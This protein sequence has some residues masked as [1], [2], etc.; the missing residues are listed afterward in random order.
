[1]EFNG[2]KIYPVGDAKLSIENDVLKVSDISDSGFDGIL[3]STKDNNKY[4]VNFGN[5][6]SISE[7]NGVLKCTT[8]QKNKLN[9]I[10]TSF[11][12]FSWYDPKSKK[13]ILGYNMDYIPNKFTVFG[14]LEGEIVYEFDNSELNPVSTNGLKLIDPVTV[15]IVLGIVSIGVAIWAELRTKKTVSTTINYDAH[16]HVVGYS[17]TITEDPIP[18][19]VEVNGK[20]YTVDEVGIKYD[21]EVPLD[22][23]GNPS[24]EYTTVAEQI[25]GVN[26]SSFEITSITIDK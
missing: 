5:L 11:E 3:I 15:T 23:I 25:T 6:S 21:E 22:L 7:N 17:R 9:Q 14:K 2:F 20:F 1:M 18:F 10:V 19:E 12:S 24:V 26:L 13:V 16:G 4:T 8:L